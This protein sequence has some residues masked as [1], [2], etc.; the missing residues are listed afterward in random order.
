MVEN[1]YRA[2]ISYSHRDREWADWLHRRLESYRVPKKLV[3]ALTLEGSVPRRL[4]PIFRDREDLPT[5]GDLTTT[6]ERALRNSHFLIVICSPAAAQSEWVSEE[7]R[8]FKALHGETRILGLIVDGVPFASEDGNDSDPAL[9]CFPLAFRRH[10]GS[11][12]ALTENKAEPLA[13]DLRDE[14]DGRDNAALKIVAGLIGVNLDD[15]IQREAHKRTTRLAITAGVFGGIAIAM[16]ALALFAFDAR[17]DAER[18]RADAEDVIEFMLTDLKGRLEAVGRLDVMDAVGQKALDYYAS[19]SADDMDADSLGRRARAQLLLGEVENLK[20]DLDAALAAYT[21]AA[22]TTEE[23]LRR[24]PNNEQRIFDHAQSVFWVGYYAWQKGDH[25]QAEEQLTKYLRHAQRLVE[26]DPDNP[27][28]QAELG[29]GY[30]N[31][32]TLLIDEEKWQAAADN[33]R[34]AIQV[35][36]NSMVGSPNDASRL[37]DLGQLHSWLAR[38]ERESGNYRQAANSLNN[39][40]DIYLEILSFDPLNME[41]K[42]ALA[43]AYGAR[44]RIAL[45]LGELAAADKDYRK[46]TDTISSVLDSEPTDTFSRYVSVSQNLHATRYFLFID[47]LPS[48]NLAFNNGKSS[49]DYLAERDINASR[50]TTFL[51]SYDALAAEMQYRAY[52]SGAATYIS[53][54]L[55]KHSETMVVATD[56]SGWEYDLATINYFA[57]LAALDNGISLDA[58]K[59]FTRGLQLLSGQETQN[60]D[61]LLLKA[62]IFIEDNQ[63]VQFEKVLKQLEEL[64]PQHPALMRMQRKN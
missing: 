27:D 4:T 49:L 61:R 39:E 18:Q 3:G 12:G 10:I 41:T 33:F 52:G 22:A 60:F 35:A 21:E 25:V 5:S 6:V 57:G 38:A 51:T 48:A 23:Q 53:A 44:A 62:K 29:Y 36:K 59:Y 56:N 46:A 28:W 8:R 2:F 42:R 19:K 54:L 7:I 9:E 20:G 58:T 47:D 14:A 32:G 1:R 24:D 11:D 13:A 37:F 31:I 45:S 17:K 30:S 26:I 40:F 15:L 43:T 16:G 34:K 64:N 63:S 55:D 50:A